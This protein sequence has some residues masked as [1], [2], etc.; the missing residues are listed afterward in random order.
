MSKSVQSTVRI[1]ILYEILKKEINENIHISTE[2]L[3]EKLAARG[4]LVEHRSV[5]RDIEA[6]NA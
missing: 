6:L 5:I 2:Q 3:I 4:I 1:F